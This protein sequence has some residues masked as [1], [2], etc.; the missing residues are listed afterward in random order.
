MNIPT[1]CVDLLDG[2]TYPAQS[3]IR[4]ISF[5]PHTLGNF[6]SKSPLMLCSPK[7]G[8]GRA[9][10]FCLIDVYQLAILDNLATITG[11]VDL[12]AHAVNLLLMHG[13]DVNPL[14]MLPYEDALTERERRWAC[15]SIRN[16]PRL[17]WERAPKSY[18]LFFSTYHI[19]GAFPVL[20]VEDVSAVFPHIH[21][22]QVMTDVLGAPRSWL[23]QTMTVERDMSSG[24]VL[25]LTSILADVDRRLATIL[26]TENS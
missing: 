13:E 25:N 24:V 8:Q 11:R 10:E 1:E 18:S 22:A 3:V 19:R 12:C 20:K 17:Y 9:R 23:D 7:P 16:S 6:L 5:T 26:Q 21:S 15:E 14:Q 4:A 2:R